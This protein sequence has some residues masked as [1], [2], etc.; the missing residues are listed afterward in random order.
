MASFFGEIIYPQ[1][2]AF[3]LRDDDDD[4]EIDEENSLKIKLITNWTEP[5]PSEFEKFL[6][7]DGEMMTGFV[8]RAILGGAKI[9]CTIRCEDK[10][11]SSKIYFINGLYI[12]IVDKELNLAHAGQ[13]TGAIAPLLSKS[14][15][16][17]ALTS[18]HMSYYKSEEGVSSASI[19]NCLYSS[20]ARNH[21][22]LKVPTLSIPNFVTGVCAGVLSYSEIADL[23]CIMYILYTDTF[24]LDSKNAHPLLELFSDL[25]GK[26]LPNFVAGGS[27]FFNKGNLYM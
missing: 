7:V 23:H 15:S 27:S 19:L 9:I 26:T 14:K 5:E 20:K 21:K 12:C 11:T 10:K 3:W 8:T 18:D 24:T 17:I 6:I 1:S 16:I 2:R 4:E 22:N 25:L 13:F